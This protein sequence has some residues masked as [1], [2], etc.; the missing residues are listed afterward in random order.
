MIRRRMVLGT[1]AAGLAC[2]VV[3]APTAANAGSQ[4]GPFAAQPRATKATIVPLSADVQ[5]V[6]SGSTDVTTS[7][8][9]R[10]SQG[11]TRTES[12]TTVTI[13]DPTTRTTLKLDTRS[14]TYQRSTGTTA[15]RDATRAAGPSKSQTLASA[16][17]SLGTARVQGVAAVGSAY[18][19]T[20]PA[21][22]HR[23]ALT[24][25]VTIWRSTQVQ[26]P[27][28]TRV[29]DPS[30]GRSYTQ[31]YTNIRA[32]VEPAASLFTVPAGYRAASAA[33]G[34]AVIQEACPLVNDDPVFL[35][36]FG[37]FLGSAVVTALTDPS[38]GCIFVADGAFFEP[39]L[40]GFPIT[41]LGLPFDQWYVFDTGDPVPFLPWVA[42]G[43]IA[44]AATNFTDTTTKDSLI[45]L[46][47]WE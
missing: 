23:P 38:I 6:R 25:D 2:L 10:D 44:F 37:P 34:G 30:S 11:R 47:V 46:T 18:T 41:G 43:D 39:P 27:V 29:V 33:T 22:K 8:L 40:A 20:I 21:T 24:K 15:A 26:L 35:D 45:I 14:R 36:S 13:N 16:P 42:F 32:G 19:V 5:V 17:R 7:R 12:G 31:T 9:Y 4:A 1:L 28:E 3:G